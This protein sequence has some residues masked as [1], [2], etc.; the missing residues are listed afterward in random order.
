MPRNQRRFLKRPGIF[1]N[2]GL[3]LLL[4][5]RLDTRNGVEQFAPGIGL[6][7]QV[8]PFSESDSLCQM[9]SRETDTE[10][11]HSVF[12]DEAQ[13][14]TKL[15]VF[16]LGHPADDVG[17]PVVSDGLW[18][19]FRVDLFEDSQHLVAWADVFHEIKTICHYGQNDNGPARRRFGPCP[20]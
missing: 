16:E 14:L 2:R 7:S 15:Q 13:F 5:T 11:V 19:D 6:T 12:L 8:T 10:T 9:C 1:R 17:I 18:T 3:L 4:T 20:P